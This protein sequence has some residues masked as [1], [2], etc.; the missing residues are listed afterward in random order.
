MGYGCAWE[1]HFTR[2]PR[3]IGEK[4]R[5]HLR[6]LGFLSSFATGISPSTFLLPQKCKLL[7]KRED[8]NVMGNPD[9]PA[10]KMDDLQRFG[11][12]YLCRGRLDC[13]D[14]LHVQIWLNRRLPL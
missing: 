10:P 5:Y 9:F 11:S 8:C 4:L 7:T 13:Q 2:G 14:H 1:V 6:C 3:G 12:R